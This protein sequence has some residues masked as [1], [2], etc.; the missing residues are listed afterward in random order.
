MT[1]SPYLL[2]ACSKDGMSAPPIRYR[3]SDPWVAIAKC[4]ENGGWSHCLLFTVE[5]VVLQRRQV[6]VLGSAKSLNPFGSRQND[7][8]AQIADIPTLAFSG[9]GLHLQLHL[10]LIAGAER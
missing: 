9:E 7:S 6:W 5:A 3:E 2:K 8:P 4:T 1:I 10:C